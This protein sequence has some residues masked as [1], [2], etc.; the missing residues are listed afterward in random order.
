MVADP[1]FLRLDRGAPTY[2]LAKYSK[3][4]KKCMKIKKFGAGRGHIPCALPKSANRFAE[5]RNGAEKALESQ[6]CGG[7]MKYAECIVTWQ[8]GANLIN[9]IK[10]D[11]NI[12][13]DG[14][15]CAM[16]NQ[17]ILIE[18]CPRIH[19]VY[20]ISNDRQMFGIARNTICNVKQYPEVGKNWVPIW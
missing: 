11:R 3:K 15:I 13:T 2:Y 18:F 9:W 17:T 4:K 20:T 19:R 1:G 16:N 10:R 6:I 8:Q 7:L 5:M 14:R 12:R